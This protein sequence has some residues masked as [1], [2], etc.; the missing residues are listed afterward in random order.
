MRAACN[1]TQQR[2]ALFSQYM[3]YSVRFD[4]CVLAFPVNSCGDRL[5]IPNHPERALIFH[6]HSFGE[7]LLNFTFYFNY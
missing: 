6:A 7:V 4:R 2:K 5:P 1:S 3:L